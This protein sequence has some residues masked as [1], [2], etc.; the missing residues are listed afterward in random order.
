MERPAIYQALSNS[1]GSQRFR[2]V[3]ELIVFVFRNQYRAPE[4]LNELRRHEWR[5]ADDLDDAV[6]VTLDKQ[7]R[8]KVHLSIDLSTNELTRRARMWG[9]LLAVT[10]YLPL[11]VVTVKAPDRTIG[12]GRALTKSPFA[13]TGQFP[14]ARWWKET[15]SEEFLRDVGAM[16]GRGDSAIFMILRTKNLSS[17]L[18]QLR[19]YGETFLHTLLE[20]RQ[21]E[22]LRAM[23]ATV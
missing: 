19:G 9:S 8:V 5:W 17:A 13:T 6:A 12:N 3:S 23:L 2:D 16:I 22:E 20:Q 15:L 14:D 18:R 21:V 4:V 7:G 1:D 10:L 11:P